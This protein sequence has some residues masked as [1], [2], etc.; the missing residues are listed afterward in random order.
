M[1]R[2]I[3]CDIDGTLCLFDRSKKN[4]YDRDFEN[5]TANEAV[6]NLLYR[7]DDCNFNGIGEWTDIIFV[8]GRND[9]FREVTRKWLD[10][11]GFKIYPLF[12][13]K[14]GDFRKDS[15]FKKELYD[16]EIKGKYNIEF[17]LDDRNQVVE[18][19]RQQ[20]LTCLQ[21]AEGDF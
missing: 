10:D 6:I 4:P 1:K 2:A 13:R 12:M 15:I 11:R 3:L 14:D 21:V 18:M 17:V 8:S 19:W 7:I 20:G 5:D 16:N 9:K